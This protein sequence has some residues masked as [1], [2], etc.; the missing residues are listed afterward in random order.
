MDATLGAASQV[1]LEERTAILS[2]STGALCG[3]RRR[4]IPSRSNNNTHENGRIVSNAASLSDL[5]EFSHTPFSGG[6]S[7]RQPCFGTV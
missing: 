4:L 1:L 5:P 2:I 3:I 7:F 6:A